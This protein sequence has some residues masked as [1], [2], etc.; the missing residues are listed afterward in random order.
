ME[1][2]LEDGK[3]IGYA[4]KQLEKEW[5]ENNFNLKNQE[6]ISIVDKVKKLKILNI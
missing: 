2:G 3:K 4:L 5:V 6:A 1:Q